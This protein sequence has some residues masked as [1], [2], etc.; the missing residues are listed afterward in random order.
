[1][2]EELR[3]VI[4]QFETFDIAL[5]GT[6]NDIKRKTDQITK[7]EEVVRHVRLQ[8]PHP[9]RGV[10]SYETGIFIAASESL[11]FCNSGDMRVTTEPMAHFVAMFPHLRPALHSVNQVGGGLIFWDLERERYIYLL[12]VKENYNDVAE[13]E[14]LK[15]C[16]E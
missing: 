1:M 11:I 9:P 13:Y 6:E 16:L 12:L 2:K 8:V 5:Q 3:R 14:R 4:P 7:N 15:E 10:V